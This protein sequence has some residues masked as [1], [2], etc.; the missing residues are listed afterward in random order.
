MLQYITG[1]IHCISYKNVM[2]LPSHICHIVLLW[3]CGM[4]LS[5]KLPGCDRYSTPYLSC[6]NSIF[7]LWCWYKLINVWWTF[8]AHFVRLDQCISSCESLQIIPRCDWH[9]IFHLLCITSVTSRWD[10]DI[11]I[12]TCEGQ[13]I[14]LIWRRLNV[15]VLP[16]LIGL[17][18]P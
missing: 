10:I 13:F 14:L 11:N 16:Y 3:I 5:S 8:Y 15:S 12:S 6:P 18:Y 4:M 1:Y 2:N 7:M 17:V 9:F